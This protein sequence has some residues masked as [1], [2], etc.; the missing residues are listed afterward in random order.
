MLQLHY[1]SLAGSYESGTHVWDFLSEFS[2]T[3]MEN[4][5]RWHSKITAVEM[6]T[7][8]ILIK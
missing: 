7:K 4:N 6:L 2:S 1:L 8:I 5:Q 3:H